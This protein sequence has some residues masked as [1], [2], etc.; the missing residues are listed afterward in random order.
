MRFAAL[1]TALVCVWPAMVLADVHK[2]ES[3]GKVTYQSGPCSDGG[4]KVIVTPRTGAELARPDGKLPVAKETVAECFNGY[5][6][7]SRDPT[8]AKMVGYVAEM[9]PAGFPTLNVDVV[10]RNSRGGPDRQMLWC[11]LNPDLTIERQETDRA[12][13][14]FYMDTRR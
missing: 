4:D 10:F 11:K 3:G 1:C 13:R 12:Q 5:R 9:A 6:I 14:Q 8:E 2:C 7:L